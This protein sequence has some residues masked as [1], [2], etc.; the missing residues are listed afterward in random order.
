MTSVRAYWASWPLGLAIAVRSLVSARS[1]KLTADAAGGRGCEETAAKKQQTPRIRSLGE[2]CNYFLI[3]LL[4]QD[5]GWVSILAHVKV[6][7]N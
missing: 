7:T 4:N 6:H 5:D 3:G 1:K 2:A